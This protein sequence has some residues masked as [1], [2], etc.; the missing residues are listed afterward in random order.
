MYFHAYVNRY[1]HLLIL[2]CPWWG[3]EGKGGR[4][5]AQNAVIQLNS[6]RIPKYI[7]IKKI[8]I[9][10]LYHTF[11]KQAEPLHLTLAGHK[12]LSP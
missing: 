5:M 6:E 1:I 11:L 7:L 2:L 4:G 12:S 9:L 8:M 10:K 3:G